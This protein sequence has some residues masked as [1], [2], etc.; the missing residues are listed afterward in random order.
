MAVSLLGVGLYVTRITANYEIEDLRAALTAQAQVLASGLAP[1]P[2]PLD[3]WVSSAATRTGA[4][5]AV[6]G[7]DGTPVADSERGAPL[8][9]ELLSVTVPA[10]G[11]TSLRLSRS[12]DHIHA[13]VNALRFLL[14]GA[15][16]LSL[17]LAAGLAFIFVESFSRQ[18][19]SLRAYTERLL[20]PQI[21]EQQLPSGD[22]DL[23]ALAQSLRRTVPRIGALLESLKLEAARREAILA[24]MVEGVLAVDKD[25]RV[26]FCNYS[27]ART[28]G[29]RMPVNR[30]HAAA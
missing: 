12:L 28:V 18:I 4:R 22:D 15:S 29:A 2:A 9:D 5:V 8:S 13:R 14:V 24:S 21:S 26:T 7:E 3:A 10:P 30:R 19:S 1:A 23:G 16:L 20:D 6:L 27:F 25:L 17:T 11:V